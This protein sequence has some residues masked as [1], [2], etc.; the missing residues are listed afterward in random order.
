MIQ[1]KYKDVILTQGVTYA[2]DENDTYATTL[3]VKGVCPTS[4]YA[5]V[6]DSYNK[7]FDP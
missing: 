2:R 3:V 6:Q 1:N 7:F 4:R 5:I